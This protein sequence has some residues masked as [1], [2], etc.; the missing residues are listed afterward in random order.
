MSIASHNQA[1]TTAAAGDYAAGPAEYFALLKPR[2]MSL[3][4]WTALAGL[5]AAP[6]HVHPVIALAAL[7]AIAV[8][9]GA[10]GALNMWWEADLDA[11]M[12]RTRLRPIPSGLI[13]PREALFFG[14]TL[15]LVAILTLA[16]AA[17][18][19]AGALLAFT[20]FFYAVVYTIWLKRLTPQN[21]V[22]GGAAGALPPVVGYAAATGSVTLDSVILFAIIFIWTP[23]HFWAL[24][25]VK[26]GDYARAGIPMM[27]NVKGAAHTRLEIV[28]YTAILVPLAILPWKT[29]MGG[30]IYLGVAAVAGAGMALMALRVYWVGDGAQAK[31]AAMQLFGFSILYLFALFTAL[32]VE[33]GFGLLERFGL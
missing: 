5:L 13:E 26:S 4:V 31:K 8:G 28:I 25:L 10:A 17:N 3:V 9:A 27:P 20:I 16:V 12:T 14:L 30:A 33:H 24:A 21:I 15:S 19:L 29:G 18:P 22:I 32:I 2:V 11:L 6:T 7:L 23:P 1:L